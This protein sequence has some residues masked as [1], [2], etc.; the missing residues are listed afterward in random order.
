M[1]WLLVVAIGSALAALLVPNFIRARAQGRLTGCKSNLKNIGTA[2]EMYSMDFGGR[3][4]ERLQRLIPNY[5]H[6]IPT[7]PLAGRDTYSDSY[8]SFTEPDGYR[9]CCAGDSHRH[10]G[11]PPNYPAYDAISGLQER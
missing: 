6:V 10:E 9:Y 3:Y 1:C 4:P 5:L 8:S 7:C 11:R 2:L